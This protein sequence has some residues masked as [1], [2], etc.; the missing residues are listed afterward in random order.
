MATGNLQ[1]PDLMPDLDETFHLEEEEEDGASMTLVEHLEE[2]RWRIFKSLIA[3]VVGAILAFIF[4]EP[5]LRFLTLPLPRL[6]DSLR[7]GPHGELA[8]KGLI[9]IGLAEGFTVFLKVSIAVGILLAMPV[10]LYQAWAFIAPGLY[11]HEKR[12]ALPFL[13]MGSILFVAGIALGFVVLQY[14]VQWLIAF[15]AGDFV[16][17]VSADSYFTFVAFFLLAFGIVFEIPLVLTFLAKLG[18][19]NVETLKRRRAAA[20]VGLW[21][22]STFITP[23]ADFY[24]PIILGVTMSCLYELTILLIRFMVRP[25]QAGT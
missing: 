1:R 25:S 8:G 23:G 21:I 12:A 4:R 6:A 10:I 13:I 11:R 3:V 17:L 14:P 5:I 2:L 20:H 16:E 22:A 24:S 18:V 7:L 15:S 9:T 19:V